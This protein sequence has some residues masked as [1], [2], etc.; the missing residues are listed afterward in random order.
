MVSLQIWRYVKLTHA[1]EV[2]QL[3]G[4]TEYQISGQGIS[5]VTLAEENQISLQEGD[6]LGVYFQ[7]T[8]PI[9]YD[10][11]DCYSSEEQ[12]RYND[13][14]RD[15]SS[16]GVE[17]EFTMAVLSWDPCRLYSIEAVI[18]WYRSPC[19]HFNVVIP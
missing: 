19:K 11:R 15:L 4:Q 6:T 3:I 7:Y 5:T 1:G 13:E 18:G 2:F 14:P 9:T 10:T 17:V 16:P 12:L 8:N